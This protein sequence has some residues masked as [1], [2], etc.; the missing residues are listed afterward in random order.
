MRKKPSLIFWAFYC[1]LIGI[2]LI[3]IIP[4]FISDIESN[5][6]RE[7]FF[8]KLGLFF[9]LGIAVIVLTFR[10]KVKGKLGKLLLL[11]GASAVGFFVFGILHNFFYALEVLTSQIKLLS[12]LMGLLHAAFF[13]VAVIICPLGFAV[14]A[15][16]SITMVVRKRKKK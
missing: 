8:L 11:T 7:F 3:T 5:I 14:G 13:I 1:A 6:M 12:Q 10:E 15:V 9:S 4:M 2:F 16:G